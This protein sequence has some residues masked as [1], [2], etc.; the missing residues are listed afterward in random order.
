MPPT[1][2]ATSRPIPAAQPPI[3]V[4]LSL[5]SHTNV[6]KTTLART[7]LHRDIG[8]VLDSEHVTDVA[9]AH[10]MVELPQPTGH[11]LLLWDTP[12][13]GDSARLA[14]RLKTSQQPV[15]S[16]LLETWDRFRNRALWCSQQA[17]KN[18]QED[19]DLVLY[20]IDATQRPEDNA[21][22]ALEMDILQWIGKPVVVVLNQLGDASTDPREVKAEVELWTRQ[23]QRFSPVK[24]V[25]ALDA[26][27]QSWVQ[28]KALLE[29]TTPHLPEWKKAAFRELKDAWQQAEVSIFQQSIGL[30]ATQLAGSLAD[31]EP[32]P[33]ETLLQKIGV[34]RKPWDEAMDKAREALGQRLTQRCLNSSDELISL[35]R[36]AGRRDDF[37]EKAD[38]DQLFAPQQVNESLWTA[39]GGILTGAAAGVAAEIKTGGLMLGGGAIV[40]IFAGGAGA[41]LL[42]KGYNLSKA[43]KD[44]LR[45]T[46]EHFLAQVETALLFYLAVSHWGRGRGTW[47]E[48]KAPRQ[49]K[50]A[51]QAALIE[52]RKVLGK[53]WKNAGSDA[54]V[55]TLESDL[56]LVLLRAAEDLLQR[57]YPSEYEA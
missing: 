27:T 53:I 52:P 6:G 31:R 23:L 30:L 3:T 24:R 55:K 33:K 44:E 46:E 56:Q 48:S 14:R 20:L 40:G 42:A 10:L 25:L 29:A 18:V 8:Q 7:L 50:E 54:E 9:E 39:V 16:F 32:A 1:A 22:V 38:R 47:Q 49:W 43:G 35:H 34:G 2:P 5:I 51:V 36:L 45:W 21:W 17:V 15:K 4:C 12:G 37:L 28:E 41:Y 26:Y 57:L 11:R 19:A 13:F